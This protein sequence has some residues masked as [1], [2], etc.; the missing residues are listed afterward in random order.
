MTARKSLL[1]GKKRKDAIFVALVLLWPIAHFA[2]FKI[3][4]N[5]SMISMSFYNGNLMSPMVYVG[6]ENYADIF[7]MFAGTKTAGIN[8][9]AA[10]W[11]ALSLIPLSLF[12]NMPLTL[13][14]SFAVFRKY[15]CHRFFRIVLFI[16]SMM[17]AV[18]LCLLFKIAVSN[19]GFVN[20]LLEMV[21]LGGK[22]PL[23]GWLGSAETAW[24][25]ILVFSVWTGIS[26]N[27]IYF[28]SSMSRV[29]DSIIESAKLDG[30]SELRL[31]LQI[32]MPL[33]WPT[34][35]TM[36]VTGFSGCFGW[37]MPSLLMTQGGP[38]GA[39]S[40]L[41][42]IITQSTKN[43]TSNLGF[44]A[45]LGIVVS[46]FGGVTVVGLRKIMEKIFPEVEY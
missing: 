42:L 31:F 10:L 3:A 7:R 23:G 13:L 24:G 2:V 26:S 17:S 16:P 27:I 18:V 35:T 32:V 6:W 29:P 45:A 34:V 4:M 20:P 25:T 37:F 44:S 40:T 38:D 12:I 36:T 14:F 43:S 9:P 21:G 39:T 33:V 15:R 5:V 41:G 11:N 19:K 22:I 1:K 30:A 8:N 28:C 46:L